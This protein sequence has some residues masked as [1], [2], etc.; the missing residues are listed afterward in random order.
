MRLKSLDLSW[1]GL[2]SVGGLAVADALMVNQSLLELDI[3]GNR[4]TQEVAN[5]MAKVL[6]TNDT[7]KVLRV[8]R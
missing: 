1:N 5:K 2:D 4:L 8:R 3:S 6:T 7:I